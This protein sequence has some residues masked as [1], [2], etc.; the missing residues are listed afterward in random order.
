M[1]D[2]ADDHAP[3]G[4]AP[5]GGGATRDR[6]RTAARVVIARKGFDATVDEIAAEAGVS[7]RTVFRHYPTRDELVVDAVK[8]MFEAAG[9][10][11]IPG[12]PTPDEDLAGWIEGLATT[13]HTRNAEIVGQAFWDIHA[14]HSSAT[15]AEI[16]ALREQSRVRGVQHLVDRAWAAAGGQGAPPTSLTWVFGLTCSA[17]TTQALMIDFGL[18]PTQIGAV[19]ADI[20][21]SALA[22]A[23]ACSREDPAT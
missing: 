3:G 14:P 5:G 15:L 7:P 21:K 16:R 6:I 9:Q 8:A 4:P 22:A 19:T 1:G 20:L 18:T 11:P 23:I 12:L 2:S 13:I 10:R 17:F